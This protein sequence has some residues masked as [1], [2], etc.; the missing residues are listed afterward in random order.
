MKQRH[1]IFSPYLVLAVLVILSVSVCPA[2]AA[3]AINKM[4]SGPAQSI[5]MGS[6]SSPGSLGSPGSENQNRPPPMNIREISADSS[7][8]KT[9]E[10]I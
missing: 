4:N 6:L 8:P 1:F 7:V 2:M 5:G 9:N 10:K 3:G